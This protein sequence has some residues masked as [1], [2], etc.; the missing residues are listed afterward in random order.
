MVSGAE[1]ANRGGDLMTDPG[2]IDI[3]TFLVVFAVSTPCESSGSTNW[4]PVL[5]RTLCVFCPHCCR[6]ASP[7]G[8]IGFGVGP[9]N[10]AKNRDGAK[11]AG[12]VILHVACESRVFVTL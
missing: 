8:N 10:G 6:Q 12:S 5:V 11:I 1:T 4:L 3:P 2:D 7:I 9:P